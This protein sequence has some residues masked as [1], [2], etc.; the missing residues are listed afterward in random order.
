MW[1][2]KI[3]SLIKQSVV[4]FI[5]IMN[6]M[7]RNINQGLFLSQKIKFQ[8]LPPKGYRIMLSFMLNAIVQIFLISCDRC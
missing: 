3:L 1:T 5:E 6:V 8:V 2:D 7:L 4:I